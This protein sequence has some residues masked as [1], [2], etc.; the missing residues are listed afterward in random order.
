MQLANS[1][2]EHVLVFI[3]T[4]KLPEAILRVSRQVA[5]L[6]FQ[7]TSIMLTSKG[8]ECTLAEVKSIKLAYFEQTNYLDQ[9]GAEKHLV[10]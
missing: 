1:L 6:R 7:K 2:P 8:R 10:P 3:G 4:L 9:N 5:F